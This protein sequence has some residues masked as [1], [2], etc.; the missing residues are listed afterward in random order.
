MNSPTY[1]KTI[2]I[3]FL[4]TAGLTARLALLWISGR[5][6]AGALSG[7][8]DAPA[9]ILLG[10]AISHGKGMAYVGQATALRAPLYPL[11]LGLLD[12]IFGSYSL[13]IM[14]IVQVFVA[15]LTA[16]MCGQAAVQLWGEDAKWVTFGL[17]M[18]IPTL[19]FFTPQIQTEIFTA[20]F[21]SLFL[22][23]LVRPDREDEWKSI[24]GMGVC[25]GVLM[26]LRFNTIFVPLIGALAAFR[27]PFNMRHLKRA[28]IPVALAG[29][30]VSPWIIRNMVVFHG[31][32][33]YSS[34]TGTTAVQGALAP[35]GRTQVGESAVRQLAEWR[36]AEWPSDIE[37]DNLS[38]LQ[39]PSEAELDRQARQAAIAAWKS[40]G[41][42]AV[43]LLAKKVSDFWFSTDQLLNTAS[44]ARWQRLIRAIGVLLYW[45]ILAGALFGWFRLRRTAPRTAHLLLFYCVL[46]TMLHLPSTMNTRLRAPLVD[47]L[48][49]ILA[50]EQISTLFGNKLSSGEVKKYAHLSAGVGA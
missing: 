48:L 45:A 50:G 23:F 18:C 16:W 17:A 3:V 13:L 4:I 31:A 49:C 7:G 27:M 25:A 33:L 37:T 30:I 22:Y 10:N 39:F 43:P 12:L 11:I 36:L 20:L 32:L 34:Q 46:A 9:Y 40:L 35:Q 28:L 38:R 1:S 21:V 41:F 26:L 8:S 2:L 19:L 44:F 14:R 24:V 6:P 29:M 15:I 5:A 47:P 42:H